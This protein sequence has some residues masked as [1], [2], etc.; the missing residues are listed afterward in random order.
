MV[1]LAYRLKVDSMFDRLIV[2]GAYNR[3]TVDSVYISLISATLAHLSILLS[4]RCILF[5]KE[6]GGGIIF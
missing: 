2:D 1:C 4:H 6:G 5:K 3:L